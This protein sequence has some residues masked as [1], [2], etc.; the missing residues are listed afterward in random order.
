[1]ILR[2]DGGRFSA[3]QQQFA[4]NT[5]E[6][7]HEPPFPVALGTPQRLVDHGQAFI[8]IAGGGYSFGEASE[9][10]YVKHF[11]PGFAQS[12]QTGAE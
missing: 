5:E 1:M 9:K 2:N 8:D 10:Y 6:L 4:F 3:Q 11:R 12:I 7:G